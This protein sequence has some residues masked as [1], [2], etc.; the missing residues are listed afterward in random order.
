MALPY[1]DVPPLDLS[2]LGLGTLSVF[3]VLAALAVVVCLVVYEWLL[4]RS[5]LAGKANARYLMVVMAVGGYLGGFWSQIFLYRPDWLARD[6]LIWLKLWNGGF[7]SV[8][9]FYGAL[10]AG[11]LFLRLRGE[12]PAA[13]VDLA[14]VAFTLGWA[15]ARFGCV[16]VHDHVGGETAFPLGVRFP[17]GV[18]RHDLG[19]YEWLFT[20]LWL[21]P[22]SLWWLSRPRRAGSF[23]SLVF[24]SYAPFRFLLDFLRE[25]DA[26]FLELTAAQWGMFGLV[27]IGLYLARRDASPSRP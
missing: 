3:S 23:I 18:I 14:W 19:L 13:Y 16:L 2:A 1:L 5:P 7:A 21:V 25:G 4:Q 17:D 27:V 24:L 12:K 26:R 8:G 10:A 15:V 6:P 20:V 9:G 11:W 22:A